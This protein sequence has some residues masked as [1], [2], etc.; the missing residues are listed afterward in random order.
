VAKIRFQADND[1]RSSIRAAVVRR[2]PA[3]DFQS[4][5]D[6]KLDGVPDPRVLQMAM[7]QGRILVSHD[8]NSMP[9]HFGRFLAEGHH[10]PGLFLVHQEAPTALVVESLLLIWLASEAEE[11]VDGIRWLLL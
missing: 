8:V 10:S 2:E 3:I 11:W 1:L 5:R 7:E 4:A 6:A 9:V